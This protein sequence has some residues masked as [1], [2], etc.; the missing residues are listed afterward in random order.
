ME[1]AGAG[2]LADELGRDPRTAARNGQ[3]RRCEFDDQ[4]LDATIELA[5]TSVELASSLE[6]LA[7]ELGD[8]PVDAAELFKHPVDVALAAER[9]RGWL[10]PWV[11]FVQMPADPVLHPCALADQRI[12]MID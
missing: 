5:G 6:Q 7:R 12:A 4:A 9:S 3:Q 8:Q 2:G 11:E 10:E 1:A